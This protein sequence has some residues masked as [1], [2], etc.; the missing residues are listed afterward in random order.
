MAVEKAF[1]A[2]P[3]EAVVVDRRH[4]DRGLIGWWGGYAQELIE[5]YVDIEQL[6]Q[7]DKW[8]SFE[9]DLPKDWEE[10]YLEARNGEISFV[11]G[12]PPKQ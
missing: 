2:A 11:Y 6:L 12:K 9:L 5:R 1:E 3:L 4:P 7:D 8:K 10:G